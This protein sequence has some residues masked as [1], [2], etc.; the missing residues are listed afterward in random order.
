MRLV[1]VRW[2]D[3][4]THCG[5]AWH[6]R[7]ELDKAATGDLEVLSVGYLFKEDE[8]NL[9]LV[10]SRGHE[11]GEGQEE[12][13]GLALTIPRLMVKSVKELFPIGRLA[14]KTPDNGFVTAQ[15]G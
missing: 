4:Y 8:R 3:C 9:T 5:Q 14:G 7:A 13:Y 15:G 2:S 10:M 6:T 12:E 1:E 11:D